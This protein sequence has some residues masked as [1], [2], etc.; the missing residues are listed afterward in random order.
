MPRLC[1]SHYISNIVFFRNDI[2]LVGVRAGCTFT[3]FTGSKLD[4]ESGV[5]RGGQTTD[6]WVVLERYLP[7]N[8]YKPPN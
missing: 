8:Y 3:G 7:K 2:D 6:T 1:G 5:I 4:G